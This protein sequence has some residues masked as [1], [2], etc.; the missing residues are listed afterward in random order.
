MYQRISVSTYQGRH[1]QDRA[2]K[3]LA[4]GLAGFR[5]AWAEVAANNQ[6][7][8]QGRVG[9]TSRPAQASCR[10][11]FKGAA[12]RNHIPDSANSWAHVAKEC[13]PL[14]VSQVNAQHPALATAEA[15][16][17]ESEELTL[18]DLIS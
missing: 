14:S 7:L 8:Y 4:D 15:I 13:Q 10:V 11:A 18:E 17:N 9:L 3:R 2:G 6:Q 12:D 5:S 1:L 16:A